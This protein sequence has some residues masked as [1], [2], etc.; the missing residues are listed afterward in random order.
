MKLKTLGLSIEDKILILVI[1][2]EKTKQKQDSKTFT[3][4]KLV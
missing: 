1:P 3:R 4:M 2:K